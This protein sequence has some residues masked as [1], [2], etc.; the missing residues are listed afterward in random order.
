ML[1]SGIFPAKCF[2]FPVVNEQMN[3]DA[4]AYNI[5]PLWRKWADP[6]LSRSSQERIPE[7]QILRSVFDPILE[8]GEKYLKHGSFVEKHFIHFNDSMVE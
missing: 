5:P 2:G 4:S 1:V 6:S 7:D 8:Y 3:L